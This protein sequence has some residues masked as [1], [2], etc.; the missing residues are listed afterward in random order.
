MMTAK[1]SQNENLA[2]SWNIALSNAKKTKQD[3]FCT[4]IADIEIE[5]KY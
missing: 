3:E 2:T 1:P 4:K 5:L